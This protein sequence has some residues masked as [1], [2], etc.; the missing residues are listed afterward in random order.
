MQDELITFETAKLAKEKGFEEYVEYYFLNEGEKHTQSGST[1][2]NYKGTLNP[3]RIWEGNNT[4]YSRPTQS[5]LQRW[6]REKCGK[7]VQIIAEYYDNG[8]NWN[9]Q[10][11]WSNKDFVNPYDGTGLYGDNGEY[12]TY[13]QA[14][15]AGLQE[16][17]KLIK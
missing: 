6:L 14:L 1:N 4:Y 2:F 17:L 12:T 3:I 9:W 16:A 15:E 8:I 5:L 13:E 10:V 7:H 11:L